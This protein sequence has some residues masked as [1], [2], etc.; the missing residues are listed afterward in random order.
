MAEETT[1]INCDKEPIHIPGKIQQQGILLAL[2]GTIIT[3][4]S[5]NVKEY[6]NLGTKDFLGQPVD[7]FFTAIGINDQVDDY[8]GACESGR[9]FPVRT[10][11]TKNGI[12]YHLV[13]HCSASSMVLELERN[14]ENPD[15]NADDIMSGILTSV[16]NARSLTSTLQFSAEKVKEIIGYDRVM[17]YKFARD[18]HGEVVA[19]AV[20]DGFEPFFGL[21]YPATDIPAQARELYK[22]NLVRIIAD[23]NSTDSPITAED[24]SMPPLDLSDSILRAVSPIHI[25]YLKNMGVA[26][27]FSVS[28]LSDGELWGLIAC[29]N[30]TP[31]NIDYKTRERCKVIS[32]LLSTSVIF[33]EKEENKE[34]KLHF[35][36]ELLKL[37]KFARQDAEL[38]ES[39]TVHNTNLLSI[40]EAPGAAIIYE[41]EVTLVGTTPTTEEVMEIAEWLSNNNRSN[42]YITTNLG[43]EFPR[44]KDFQEKAAGI[45]AIVLS[46]E[47]K[48]YV[49]WFKPEL[50]HSIAWAGNPE[51]AVHK[52]DDGMLRLSPRNSFE[53]FI[54]EIEG[55]SG[56]WNN[57]EIVIAMKFREEILGVLNEKATQVRRLNEQLRLAYDELDTFSFTISH[58]LKTPLA[59]IKNYTEILLESSQ[60]SDDAD[61]M[62]LSKIIRGADKMNMLINEV[63]SYTRL[64]RKP[65]KER[66]I[67]MQDMLQELATELQA[68]FILEKPVIEIGKTPDIYGDIVMIYQVFSNLISNAIKYSG[69]GKAARVEINGVE[70]SEGITYTITDNGIGIDMKYGDQIFELFKRMSNSSGVEGT[71]VGLAIVKRI[72]QKHGA[73]IWYESE[74]GHGTSFFIN[75][76]V[77]SL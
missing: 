17:I 52:S 16:L 48:E 77:N 4:I 18:G 5:D 24:G 6:F 35:N 71:G 54:E 69:S 26:A 9:Q 65:L 41:G 70:S 61:K 43:K 55:T 59:S 30:Y 3:H 45:L 39:I 51:K 64:T 33:R 28:L 31:K 1:L 21:H 22:R 23:V 46:K 14:E 29:H 37:L 72:L 32:Q 25:Q 15:T 53:S 67:N 40:S 20:N 19:E 47:L 73:S 50:K 2:S 75:F 57:N 11:S 49:I 44:G 56:E 10:V 12:N 66:V 58:D 74:T 60:D 34:L 76:K 8:E 36:E 38:G 63:L 62:V 68:A 7:S 13:S 27:S 42:F